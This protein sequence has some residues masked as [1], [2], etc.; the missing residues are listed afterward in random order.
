M[1]K[2][3]IA[4]IAAVAMIYGSALIPQAHE[5]EPVKGVKDDRKASIDR[6]DDTDGS[7]VEADKG[8]ARTDKR[9]DRLPCI[10]PVEVSG[11]VEG[12]EVDDVSG[13]SDPISEGED[14]NGDVE[15]EVCTDEAEES[16]DEGAVEEPQQGY[17]EV[18]TAYEPV[19][20]YLGDWTISFYCNCSQCCGSWSGG[21]TASGAMPQAWWTCATGDLPFGTILYVD[22][23]GEFEVQDRGTGY[24]WL[25]VFVGS[26]DEALANGLQYRSVWRTKR[27]RCLF[28]F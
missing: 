20:E 4:V 26:H 8:G 2:R 7:R 14:I 5:G 12:V 18:E 28:S 23:L 27:E 11:S 9:E 1:K 13:D 10:R 15:D 25:D 21:P 3:I 6:K 19:M 22:G 24:G 17:T 16:R